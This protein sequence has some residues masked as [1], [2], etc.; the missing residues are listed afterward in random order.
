[1]DSSTP[2]ETFF[3]RLFGDDEEEAN[4]QLPTAVMIPDPE[5]P[6]TMTP[7][8]DEMD[9][10]MSIT[11]DV[12]DFP[13]PIPEGFPRG[14]NLSLN[15]DQIKQ[16]LYFSKATKALIDP[17]NIYWRKSDGNLR[18]RFHNILSERR[19]VWPECELQWAYL[20][21]ERVLRAN[22]G[23][24]WQSAA[25]YF[26]NPVLNNR[27]GD[28]RQRAITTWQRHRDGAGHY[29]RASSEDREILE[30]TTRERL[31]TIALRNDRNT[32]NPSQ[33]SFQ[34]NPSH[35][36]R[37]QPDWGVEE[38]Q[39]AYFSLQG[40]H[41]AYLSNIQREILRDRQIMIAQRRTIDA[42]RTII[43]ELQNNAGVLTPLQQAILDSHD[44]D[45]DND[46][47]GDDNNDDESVKTPGEV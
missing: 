31:I 6:A 14:E 3:R 5:L 38:W 33:Y 46:L 12:V 25:D 19:E 22:A 43:E 30:G 37:H 36:S 11:S 21:P 45:L 29:R 20:H 9:D 13:V 23:A 17:S 24:K 10:T 35:I 18:T 27:L 16:A 15:E 26:H 4:E 28:V 47:D 32:T 8:D 2:M 39:A 1:M 42:Q 44:D 34:Q 7:T 41:D 40:T